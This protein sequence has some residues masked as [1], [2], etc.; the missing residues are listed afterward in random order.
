MISDTLLKNVSRE[1]FDLLSRYVS[2]LTKWNARINLVGRS[3]EQEIWTRHIVDSLQLVPFIPKNISM[4]DLGSG[5]GIPG[6]ILAIAR[7]DISVTLIEIDQRKCA[8]LREAVATLSLPNT[9]I[10]N[11]GIEAVDER[12]DI[13]SAR[14]LA[15]LT[16]LFTLAYP[17]LKPDAFCLFPKGRNFSK[18]LEEAKMAWQFTHQSQPSN[19]EE[20]ACILTI[21]QLSP[22]QGTA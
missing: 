21:T 18:E 11:A 22:T 7:P 14:A 17:L 5:A 4:A 13:V 20:G 8:F 2:L 10:I 9:R 6:L 12:F 15:S 16:Q 19:T 3:T 1:T